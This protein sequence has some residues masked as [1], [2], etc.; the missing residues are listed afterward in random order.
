[1][2]RILV[3]DDD[4]GVRLAVTALLVDAGYEVATAT[5][6]IEAFAEIRD[7]RPDAVLLDLTMAQM[8]GWAFLA[9]IRTNPKLRG[10]PI[11]V[12]SASHD[13]G[14][15]WQEPA[16]W[17]VIP[18]PFAAEHLLTTVEGLVKHSIVRHSMSSRT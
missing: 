2:T 14:K 7:R 4:F 15:A 11:G 12:L 5:N 18:K 10:V 9:T 6:G 3:V 8:D 13:A 16:V 17:A 1:M